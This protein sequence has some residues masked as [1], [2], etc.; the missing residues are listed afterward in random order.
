MLPLPIENNIPK[1]LKD[2]LSESEDGQALIDF[3]NNFIQELNQEILEMYF[4]KM[5]ER[6]PNTLLNELGYM[7]NAGIKSFDSERTKR[8]KIATAVRSHIYRGTWNND[9]KQRVDAI[10][11][12]DSQIFTS[13]NSAAFLNRGALSSEPDNYWASL[14][15]NG[16]D[17]NLGI[18]NL[19]SFFESDIP[20][21]IYIDVDNDSLTSDKVDQLVI[22]LKDDVLP[23]YMRIF[24]GYLDG[25]GQFQTYSILG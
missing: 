4:F 12:G 8:K 25:A 16:I 13:T 17:D 10:A 24:L 9:V 23:A 3:L 22:D 15:T 1:I 2:S 5:P 21:N 6:I 14:G 18:L 11:G 20:G 7:L 19:G